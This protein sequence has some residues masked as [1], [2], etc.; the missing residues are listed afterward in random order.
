MN[1]IWQGLFLVREP[2]FHRP[3]ELALGLMCPETN[4]ACRKLYTGSRE[5][6]LFVA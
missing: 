6:Y 2:R 4:W 3:P 5:F 1:L